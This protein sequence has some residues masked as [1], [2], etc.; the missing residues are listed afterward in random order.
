M[1]DSKKDIRALS[2][3]ELRDFFVQEGDKAFRG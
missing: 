2:K 3:D 1:K